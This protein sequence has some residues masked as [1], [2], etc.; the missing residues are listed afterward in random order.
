MSVHCL[1]KIY[2]HPPVDF[3]KGHEEKKNHALRE[4]KLE[5]K[6][7]NIRKNRNGMV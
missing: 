1:F 3:R 7:N 2:K 5:G 4:N 6:T